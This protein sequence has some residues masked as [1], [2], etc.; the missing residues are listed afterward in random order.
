MT[1]YL[2]Y[3][4]IYEYLTQLLNPI[5]FNMECNMQYNNAKYKTTIHLQHL[6]TLILQNAEQLA[7][8]QGQIKLIFCFIEKVKPVLSDSQT[9]LQI[10]LSELLIDYNNTHLEIINKLLSP[11]NNNI[12]LGVN[13]IPNYS[14]PISSIIYIPDNINNMT[15]QDRNNYILNKSCKF[16]ETTITQKIIEYKTSIYQLVCNWFA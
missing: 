8:T 1:K 5:Q 10:V 16:I 6:L 11:K 9:C 3:P 13:M 2:P 4:N 7:L 14:I 12:E 15:A